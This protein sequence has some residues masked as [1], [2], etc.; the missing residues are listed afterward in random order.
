MRQGLGHVDSDR[1]GS[2]EADRTVVEEHP[3]RAEEIH[4]GSTALFGEV[5]THRGE[6]LAVVEAAIGVSRCVVPEVEVEV[7]QRDRDHRRRRCSGHQRATARKQVTHERNRPLHAE[8]DE[9]ARG[10]GDDDVPVALRWADQQ[11]ASDDRR[12]RNPRQERSGLGSSPRGEHR[13][14]P[15]A[16][17]SG[18][19]GSSSGSS[20]GHGRR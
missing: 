1:S 5:V 4:V 2:E 19:P 7:P 15:A 10:R 6:L 8:R 12:T 3:R 14:A 18:H 9:D 13:P 20:S 11:D 16:P 17:R